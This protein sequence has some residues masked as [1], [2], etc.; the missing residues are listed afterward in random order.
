MLSRIE[1]SFIVLMLALLLAEGS[2]IITF[3]ERAT[4]MAECALNVEVIIGENHQHYIRKPLTAASSD[5]LLQVNH[6]YKGVV[7]NSGPAIVYDVSAYKLFQRRKVLP[8]ESSLNLVFV[9]YIKFGKGQFIGQY[10]VKSCAKCE[11][12]GLPVLIVSIRTRH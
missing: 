1:Q 9:V 10:K 5:P 11:Y 3:L 7:V 2:R 8:R 6:R 4:S 12:V